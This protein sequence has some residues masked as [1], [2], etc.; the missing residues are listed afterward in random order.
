MQI[1][2]IVEPLN[3]DNIANKSLLN[4]QQ[5]NTSYDKWCDYSFE[6]IQLHSEMIIY[7][8]QRM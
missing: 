8:R 1:A 2:N 7:K 4:K 6:E 5:T 3:Y